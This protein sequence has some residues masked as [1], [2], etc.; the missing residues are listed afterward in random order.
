MA[1]HTDSLSLSYTPTNDTSV[2]S[3][4]W[5]EYR[6]IGQLSSDG[7]LEFNISGNSHKYVDLANTRLKIKFRI[8]QGDGQLLPAI[9]GTDEP[10]RP[11]ANV[12]PVNLFLQSLWQQVD[13]F[14]QQQAI[15][16]NVST[17][18]PHKA[19]IETLLNYSMNAKESQLQ[20]QLYYKD[21][22]LPNT[23][24]NDPLDSGNIGLYTRTRMTNQS[25]IVDLESRVQ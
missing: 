11:K 4:E 8:V 21:N 15:S 7:A 20:S 10:D 9:K 22:E 3:V 24:D 23:A 5:V 6:P 18:Y 25:A 13:V 12:G 1:G 17:K 16:P 2:R 19:Y 14:L